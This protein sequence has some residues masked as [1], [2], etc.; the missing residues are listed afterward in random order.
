MMPPVDNVACVLPDTGQMDRKQQAG[1]LHIIEVYVDDFIQMVQTSNRNAP[2]EQRA[3]P[4]RA[5]R[6]PATGGERTL[7]LEPSVTGETDGW[8]GAVGC[9]HGDLELD[10]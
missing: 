2:S 6:V 5:Q 3:A 10:I 1:F 9:A 7:W 8:R 4:W